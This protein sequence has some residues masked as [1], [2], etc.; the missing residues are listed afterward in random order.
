MTP[1]IGKFY[2]I[3]YKDAEQPKG[4]YFGIARCVGK[5]ERDENGQNLKEPFYEFEHPLNDHGMVRQL[6]VSREIIM[7]AK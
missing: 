5:Y 6:Y 2:Y 4:S 1:T 3:D 7:E